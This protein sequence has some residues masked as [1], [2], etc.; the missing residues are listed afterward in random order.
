MKRWVVAALA[1]LYCA[2]MGLWCWFM[3]EIARPR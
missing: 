1:V 2:V 3:Y